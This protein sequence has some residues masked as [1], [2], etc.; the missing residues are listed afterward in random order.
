MTAIQANLPQ[1]NLRIGYIALGSN[2]DTA[3]KTS[4]E[5]LED[6]LKLLNTT[7]IRITR[8]SK[9]YRTPAF[10][11]GNGP[12][13]VNAVV[14]IETTLAATA[15][16]AALHDIENTLG[17]ARP[18][19]W[20][21]RVIDLDLIALGAEVAPDAATFDHWLS[22]PLSAQMKT[23]PSE[24]I[25]PHPRLQDRAFVLVPLAEIAPKWRHPVLE[26]TAEA[27]LAALPAADRA[28]INAL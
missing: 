26:E 3:T 20:A 5:F 8:T 1:G 9:A 22:L 4:S 6:S 21:S 27:L 28:E 13:Y 14:E 7:E 2:L 25:L 18:A 11:A 15:V 10:P 24:L 23:A 19:R 12:D 16:L 17:R